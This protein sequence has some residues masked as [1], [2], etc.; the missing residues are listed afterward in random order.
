MQGS[1][2]DIWT[3]KHVGCVHF[4]FFIIIII[5][6]SMTSKTV[7]LQDLSPL[8]NHLDS[9]SITG[10]YHA[11][12]TAQTSVGSCTVNGPTCLGEASNHRLHLAASS[13]YTSVAGNSPERSSNSSNIV[14]EYHGNS[15]MVCSIPALTNISISRHMRNRDSLSTA[16]GSLKGGRLNSNS[17]SSGGG[18]APSSSFSVSFHGL[19][20]DSFR[21]TNS[22]RTGFVDLAAAA[23]AAV[24]T[25]SNSND[26]D[27]SSGMSNIGGSEGGLQFSHN[28]T[29]NCASDSV[30]KPRPDAKFNS[31]VLR[32]GTVANLRHR[33]YSHC[34]VTHKTMT[35]S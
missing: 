23:A 11:T 19:G 5:P 16:V 13:S 22:D 18:E 28:G 35:K 30:P 4:F 7:S 2:V 29:T 1:L 6:R 33:P 10:D 21:L 24:I 20:R 27:S 14:K 32:S 15:S 17:G 25:N 9:E 34:S 3:G 12:S 8:N 26:G 31:L